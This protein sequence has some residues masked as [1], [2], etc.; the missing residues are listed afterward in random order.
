MGINARGKLG[1][2]VIGSCS[3]PTSSLAFTGSFHP[4]SE[5]FFSSIVVPELVWVRVE[6]TPS[7]AVVEALSA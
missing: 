4:P 7:V 5:V 1:N 3:D 2:T 6:V